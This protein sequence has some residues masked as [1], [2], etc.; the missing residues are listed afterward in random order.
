VDCA[1]QYNYSH[2]NDGPGLMVYTYP[3]S[4]FADRGCVVRFNISEND[5]RKGRRYAGLWV[6]T[7]G[8][9]ITGLDIY[10]NTVIVG[11]WTDQAALINAR[12]VE[13]HVRNNIFIAAA[14]AVPLR[15]DQPHER[16]RFEN[17]LYWREGGPTEISWGA[18][19]YSSLQEWREHTGQES[20]NGEPAG[21]FADPLLSR[22]SP[23][24]RPGERPELQALRVFR[25]L[26]GSPALAGGLDL[27]KKFGLDTGDRDFLGLLPMAGP[28]PL[29]AIGTPALE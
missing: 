25:P 4:S 20:L 3:Y 10:N 22:P 19:T 9:E 29:G 2:D 28:F 26:P 15:V 18:Q 5:A 6:R 8:K 27:R 1:L 12:G 7:D 17:N 11:P 13:A 23:D 14:P 24:A 21:F 16:V